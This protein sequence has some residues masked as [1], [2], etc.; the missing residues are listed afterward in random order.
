MLTN[1]FKEHA[2]SRRSLIFYGAVLLAGL[3]GL[4][5]GAGIGFVIGDLYGGN[6][7][8][9]FEFAGVRGYEATG[10]LGVIIGGIGG[11]AVSIVVVWRSRSRVS[12]ARLMS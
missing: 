12:R 1:R 6:Y 2:D 11:A 3:L 9:D 10:V 5:A 4:V 7:A 8:V